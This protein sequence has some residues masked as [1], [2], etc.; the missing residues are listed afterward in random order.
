V[1]PHPP[2]QKDGRAT[3]KCRQLVFWGATLKPSTTQLS[4]TITQAEIA[5]RCALEF[6]VRTLSD[7]PMSHPEAW[8]RSAGVPQ[9]RH[10]GGNRLPYIPRHRDN[11]LPCQLRRARAGAGMAALRAHGR[12]SSTPG[13][14]DQ[15][16][17]RRGDAQDAPA[18]QKPSPREERATTPSP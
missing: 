13:G 18:L 10:L 8:R 12:P 9:R 11:R 17:A 5:T 7:K 6:V 4:A 16:V 2:S 1:L 15:T 14:E 3:A